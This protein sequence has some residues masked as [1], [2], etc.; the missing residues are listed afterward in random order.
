MEN[1]IFP[2]NVSG[3][4]KTYKHQ[5]E[6]WFWTLSG[7]V[8]SG[9]LK[10]TMR[11]AEIHPRGAHALGQQLSGLP[12]AQ[13]PAERPAR[14]QDRCL[15]PMLPETRAPKPPSAGERRPVFTVFPSS[16]Q[17]CPAVL[18]GPSRLL[19]AAS[20]LIAVLPNYL[21]LF[22]CVQEFPCF[23]WKEELYLNHIKNK[24]RHEYS[25]FCTV[26]TLRCAQLLS[27]PPN[28]EEAC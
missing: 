9:S 21:C 4:Q 3:R 1:L 27:F 20:A 10:L 24:N 26:P 28:A 11:I 18:H 7:F 6:K 14:P 23:L 15:P 13:A 2:V 5:K 16:I 22:K 8:S 12:P 25:L 17:V 19:T